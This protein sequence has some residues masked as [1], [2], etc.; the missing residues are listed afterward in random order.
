MKTVINNFLL[1]YVDLGIP[2]AQP[3]ILIHGFPFSH[4]MWAFPGGQIEAL[5]STNRVIAYDVRGHGESEVGTGHYSIE[6]FV[7][8]LIGLMKKIGLSTLVCYT[9]SSFFSLLSFR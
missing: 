7:D 1:R 9:C 8:D 2:T 4:K 5:S 6:F 3:I